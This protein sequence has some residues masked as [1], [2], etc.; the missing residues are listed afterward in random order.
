MTPKQE[1]FVREYLIDLNAAQA[2]IRAGYSVN[3]ARAIG[4]ENLTKP[5]IQDAIAA[6]QIERARRTEITSD[7]VL[8]ELGRIGFADIRRL[9]DDNGKLKH[10]TML[11]DEVA[12]SISSVEVDAQKRRKLSGGE[13]RDEYDVEATIKVKLWDKRAALVDMG[14]HLGMFTDKVEHSGG[15]NVIVNKP[16]A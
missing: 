2:A 13:E 14:R 12:A 11:D 3:T 8:K 15:V 6:A 7:R 4:A 16:G 5:D 9:F 1:Q 10:I